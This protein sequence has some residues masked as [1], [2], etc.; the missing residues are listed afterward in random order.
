VLTGRTLA[1]L[2]MILVNMGGRGV[3]AKQTANRLGYSP[4]D[5]V[6]VETVREQLE[7][8]VTSGAARANSRPPGDQRV[9][10]YREAAP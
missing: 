7:A 6:A 4:A 9:Y 10:Y 8:W 2:R 1:R 3:T 5:S